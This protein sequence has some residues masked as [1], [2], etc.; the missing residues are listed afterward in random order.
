MAADQ[1]NFKWYRYVDDSARNWAI[2]AD[3][4]WGDNTDSGLAT[5]NVDDPPFG[6]QSKRHHPRKAVYRDST[7]FRVVVLVM[8]TAAAY[9]AAPSTVA[10]HVPGE[11]ATVTYSLVD[12]VPEKLQLP[13]TSRNLADHA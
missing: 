2:R 10:I 13:Q 8:G 3:S 5:F 11:T 9:A 12:K 4:N 6:P 7:T 1:R